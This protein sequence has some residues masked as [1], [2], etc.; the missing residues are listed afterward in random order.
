MSIEDIQNTFLIYCS[1]FKTETYVVEQ[2]DSW[3]VDFFF[4]LYYMNA[5]RCLNHD[6][7]SCSQSVTIWKEHI[8]RPL[9]GHSK[10]SFISIL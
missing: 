8:D 4:N 5:K 2:E 1:H 6:A 3:S 10:V 7:W 9:L